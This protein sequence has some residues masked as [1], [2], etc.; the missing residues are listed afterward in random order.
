MARAAVIPALSLQGLQADPVRLRLL[1]GFKLHRG[2]EIARLPWNAQRVVAFLALHDTPLRRDHVAQSLWLDVP[3]PRAAANLRT[4]LWRIHQLDYQ[5]V[6]SE[7]DEI[8]LAESVV[9]DVRDVAAKARRLLDAGFEEAKA[10]LTVE[11]LDADLLPGWY[12]EWVLL[13]QERFRQL[14]LH[15]LEALCNRLVGEKRFAEAVQAGLTAVASEPLRETAQC[16]LIAA[17][18]AEGN[19]VDAIRQYHSYQS[20]LRDSLGLDPG[21]QLHELVRSLPVR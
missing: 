16:A 10:D 12:E 6:E 5:V 17:F 7:R 9:V 20:L 3:E 19:V 14:R 4:A 8:Q 18:L 11:A 2:R 21:P 13:E 1:K 15:A